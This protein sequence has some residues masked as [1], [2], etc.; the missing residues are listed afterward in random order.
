MTFV[1]LSALTSPESGALAPDSVGVV[2]IG[3]LE[4]HGP[5]L[6]LSTDTLITEALVRRACE[7][8]AEPVAVAPCL[9]VGV[10][11]QHAGFPGT[12]TLSAEL[13]ARIVEV[14]VDGFE[15]IG[16]RRVGLLSAHAGNF[17]PLA[18]ADFSR[19][20]MRVV[21]YHDFERFLEVLL[22][23]ARGAGVDAPDCDSHAGAG[24]TGLVLHLL[25][26]SAVRE[27]PE[28]TGYRGGDPDWMAQISRGIEKL[29]PD[30]V[31]GDPA[32]ASA[33]A[34][35]ASFEA[36]AAEWASWLAATFSLTE[37]VPPVMT[38]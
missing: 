29:S 25:G 17:S 12:F 30:G 20:P 5:H 10:S 34:G 35:R 18:A 3:A 19:G 32:L 24:E 33:A 1:E 38:G 2:P 27:P 26:S 11:P 28:A 9:P 15:R 6:P 23:A 13:L 36:L 37:V 31:L 8:V 7:L 4:Q 21:A 22:G 14:Y 16:I